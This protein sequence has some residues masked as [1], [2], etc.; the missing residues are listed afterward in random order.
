MIGLLCPGQGAQGGALIERLCGDEKGREVFASFELVTGL[1]AADLARGP[2]EGLFDNA[3]AQPMV[4]AIALAAFVVFEDRLPQVRVIA[5]Y[6]IGELAAYGCAGA[7]SPLDTLRLSKIRADLMEAAITSPSAMVAVRG[8]SGKV[9]Q[10]LCPAHAV[11]IAIRNGADR[12]VI[13]GN[14]ENV[15]NFVPAALACGAMITPLPVH[16]PSHTPLLAKAAEQFRAELSCVDFGEP[17]APVI[18]G[19]DGCPVLSKERAIAT[20]SRQICDS[21]DWE[22]CMTGLKESGARN[23]LELGS[24]HDLSRMLREAYP[25]TSARSIDE[26]HTLAGVTAWLEAKS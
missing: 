6:S 5:G 15:D 17:S 20:L 21:V 8:V 24:G 14:R 23:F 4:C 7:I 19:I 25:E 10:T 1:S 26:F 9:M 18:A 13:A 11:H 16:V 3:V 22:A 2:R 12:F